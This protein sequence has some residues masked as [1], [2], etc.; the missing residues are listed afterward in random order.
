MD[1]T[2]EYIKM[3][4]KAVEIQ[5]NHD[6][7]RWSFTTGDYKQRRDKIKIGFCDGRAWYADTTDGVTI[8]FTQD[9]LQ[10]MASGSTPIA[11]FLFFHDYID[12]ELNG[13]MRGNIDLMDCEKID[14]Y[15]LEQLWL[16]CI[17]KQLYN[18][19]WDGEQWTVTNVGQN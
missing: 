4:E 6:G 19:T 1:T 5:K 7:V 11:K 9:Q 18:K 17:M 10:E 16:M 15:S 12:E 14:N 2:K 3:C 13:Y 8:I